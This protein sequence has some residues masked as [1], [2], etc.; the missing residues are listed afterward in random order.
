MSTAYSLGVSTESSLI[1]GSTGSK[2]PSPSAGAIV[3]SA[4][5]GSTIGSTTVSSVV[6]GT[7]SSMT[8]GAI[9]KN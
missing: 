9:V 6:T 4:A 2:D 7:A 1:R 8:R 5:A 3:S